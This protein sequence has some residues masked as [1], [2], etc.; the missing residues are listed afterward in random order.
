MAWMSVVEA[1]R[2]M[3]CSE[4]TVRRRIRNAKLHSEHRNGRAAV[5]IE[6]DQI[7]AGIVSSDDVAAL[8]DKAAADVRRLDAMLDSLTDIDRRARRE[9]HSGRRLSRLA[10]GALI[11]AL[12]AG[13]AFFADFTQRHRDEVAALLER[14]DRAEG[15]ATARLEAVKQLKGELSEARRL[16][17]ESA[18]SASRARGQAQALRSQLALE[19][20]TVRQLRALKVEEV[21]D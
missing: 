1:A 15:A 2:K 5:W 3:S 21:I 9:S 14:R 19:R 11:V 12:V 18:H 17:T 6:D 7:V 8:A 10:P 16:V 4:G 20:E 13:G